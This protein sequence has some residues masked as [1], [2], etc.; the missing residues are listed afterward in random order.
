M[1]CS[2]RNFRPSAIPCL[3][4]NPVHEGRPQASASWSTAICCDIRPA[5]SSP[6]MATTHARSR[7]IWGIGPSPR[8]C[9]TQP[10]RRIASSTSGGIEEAL[11]ATPRPLT[12][13]RRSL[14]DSSTVLPPS[15]G[16]DVSRVVRHS[17]IINF[18]P[19]FW[20]HKKGVRPP[21]RNWPIAEIALDDLGRGYLPAR[22]L[23]VGIVL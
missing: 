12:I 20:S 16:K 11:Y 14:T 19:Q 10:S 15:R 2:G 4:L 6:T 13:R 18:G 21:S 3:N 7:I 9:A 22:L 23:F 8:P 17:R 5:T 1:S